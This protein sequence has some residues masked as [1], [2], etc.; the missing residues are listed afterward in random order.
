MLASH[1]RREA[2][3]RR[4]I[5]ALLDGSRAHDLMDLESRGHAS[6]CLAPE[7]VTGEIA[8]DKSL[9]RCTNDDSI[10]RGQPLE[11]GRKIGRLSQGELLLPPAAPHR[12]HDD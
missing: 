3:G 10:R 1:Q 2:V 8:L 9:R 6:E 11:A 12:P 5:E 7:R 4:D